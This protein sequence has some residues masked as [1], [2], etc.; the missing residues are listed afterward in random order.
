MDG[1]ATTVFV[2]IAISSAMRNEIVAAALWCNV[3]YET[4]TSRTCPV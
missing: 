1:L 2:A 3:A 4:L